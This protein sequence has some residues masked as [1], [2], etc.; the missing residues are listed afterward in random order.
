MLRR[1]PNST[2]TATPL[3]STPLFRSTPDRAFAGP[4]PDGRADERLASWHNRH[5]KQKYREHQRSI[6][7]VACVML[8]G[9]A[10][11]YPTSRRARRRGYRSSANALPGVAP[12]PP[13][14]GVAQRRRRTGYWSRGPVRPSRA[15]PR[16]GGPSY[17]H[18]LGAWLQNR[19]KSEQL[20]KG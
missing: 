13:L 20:T 1:P 15:T 2:R 4:D 18:R 7:E 8:Q 17:L 14:H 19:T 12:T 9:R 11:M 6:R 3:P 5:S 16:D 10:A